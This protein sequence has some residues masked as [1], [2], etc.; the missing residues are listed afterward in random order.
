MNSPKKKGKTKMKNLKNGK[1]LMVLILMSLCLSSLK[2]MAQTKEYKSESDGYTWYRTAQN[3]NYGAQTIDGT[4]IIPL[5]RKYT[6]V[7]YHPSEG[8][9]FFVRKNRLA[10]MCDKYGKEV[11][12]P[13][14]YDNV[15]KMGKT[16]DFEY[17]KVELKGSNGF[18]L[19]GVYNIDGQ[20]IIS[21]IYREVIY[22]DG[23]FHCDDGSA[24]SNFSKDGALINV[25]NYGKL[26]SQDVYHT[27]MDVLGQ[28]VTYNYQITIYEN[29]LIR[30]YID[31]RGNLTDSRHSNF[32]QGRDSSG[33]LV[34]PGNDG[35]LVV[36][37][38]GTISTK[39]SSCSTYEKGLL[40][41]TSISNGGSYNNNG[42]YNGGN[43][44]SGNTG[45]STTQQKQ[46]KCG[47][48]G[49]TGRVVTNDIT[50]YGSTATKYCNECGKTVPMYHGHVPCKNC[51][52]KGWW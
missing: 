34:Y 10:G 45:T 38:N 29:A 28:P 16:N 14:K 47:V 17:I 6:F 5:N 18:N 20:E 33:G 4:T 8:G 40:L 36:Q 15:Y 46:H 30:T 3:G 35:I 31:E 9:W 2:M 7:C 52:G 27:F 39:K 37:K 32:Y 49:G 41:S 24:F 1:R 13:E 26:T 22:S 48:C 23:I 42:N 51:G 21:P 11:L 25:Q 44:G 19:Y 50:T 12:A 43:T